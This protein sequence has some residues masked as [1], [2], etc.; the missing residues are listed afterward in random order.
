MKTN[1]L[2]QIYD[3]AERVYGEKKGAWYLVEDLI[4]LHNGIAKK[5]NYQDASI[6]N[7][8]LRR[9]GYGEIFIDGTEPNF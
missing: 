4:D 9:N 8:V 3:E 7:R 5:V 6:V 1:M 2:Q